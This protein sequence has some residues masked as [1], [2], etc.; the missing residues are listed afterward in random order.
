MGGRLLRY[1]AAILVSGFLS[2]FSTARDRLLL[3]VALLL[4]V[5]IGAE[6][7]AELQEGVTAFPLQGLMAAGAVIAFIA[8]FKLERRLS[9][10][11]SE[12]VLAAQALMPKQR[13]CYAALWHALVLALLC[14]TLLRMAPLG[15]AA[16]SL[17]YL[18]GV[19]LVRTSRRS[20]Q[21]GDRSSSVGSSSWSMAPPPDG[22]PW[23]RIAHLA[24]ARQSII[25]NSLAGA[26]AVAAVAALLCFALTYL[27]A[28]LEPGLWPL[29]AAGLLCLAA[30][31]TFFRADHALIRFSA[32]LGFSAG[33]TIAGHLP[34][35]TVFALVYALLSLF[36]GGE[37]ASSVSAIAVLLWAAAALVLCLR[38]LH[39]RLSAKKS[40]DFAVQIQLG[41]VV[42]LGVL[43]LPLAI[44][45]AITR[46][47]L[48]VR[49]SRL[50]TWIHP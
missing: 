13:A 7:L 50:A 23:L 8:Q 20:T 6:F 18:G 49:R 36:L 25:A 29:I 27:V 3:L 43:F 19:G 38:I 41:A 24:A 47:A 45:A 37:L 9:F 31:A 30:L 40:A 17:S 48:L 16:V 21:P 15:V 4:I 44:L 33:A 22:P 14:L 34:V 28:E 32:F 5:F 35:G 39:Y 1:E 10:L 12:S 42:A 2:A 26:A 46:V 11:G